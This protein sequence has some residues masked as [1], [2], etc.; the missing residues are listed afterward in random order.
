MSAHDESF[1]EFMPL[2]L[3]TRFWGE[4]TWNKYREGFWGTKAG[5]IDI[6]PPYHSRSC[7]IAHYR[8]EQCVVNL[9]ETAEGKFDDESI[10]R[11]WLAI[12]KL[13]SERQHGKDSCGTGVT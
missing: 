13:V 12:I 8:Y 4:N 11:C 7:S 9:F 1:R 10:V 6:T 3:T 5:Q 2:Q